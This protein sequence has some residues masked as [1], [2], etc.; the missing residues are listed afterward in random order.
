M[1]D[2]PQNRLAAL[3]I[4][5]PDAP[6][7]AANYIPFVQT[8]NL[9]FISGQVPMVDGAIEITG[10]VGDNVSI[11]QAQGQAR[12]C[13]INILAQ[14]NA[15]T[16]GDLSKIKRIVK[17]GGFVVCTDDF[18]N[19]PE[20]INGASDLMADVFGEAGQHARFAVG[21]NA[22]PRGVVV[23]IDAVIELHDAH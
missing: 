8:G 16:K 6:A 17:L 13:A 23:E 15:A 5:L 22:L 9:L 7:P 11:E 10:K 12:I 21:T 2:T 19:Q 4:T 20:V 3:G 18:S 14:A 1:S